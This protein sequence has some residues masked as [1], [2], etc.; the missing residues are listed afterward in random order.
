MV[1]QKLTQKKIDELLRLIKKVDD[2]TFEVHYN[3]ENYMTTNG[4]IILR[5]KLM[6]FWKLYYDVGIHIDVKPLDAISNSIDDVNF[7][8]SE[9][10]LYALE[11]EIIKF[12]FPSDSYMKEKGWEVI[13]IFLD[14][15]CLEYDDSDNM[16]KN[17]DEE[18]IAKAL[19]KRNFGEYADHLKSLL[20]FQDAVGN[21]W[22]DPCYS[23]IMK[24][25]R[26][27]KFME[28]AESVPNI[29][30]TKLYKQVKTLIDGIISPFEWHYTDFESN[31]VVDGCLYAFTTGGCILE[32]GETITAIHGKLYRYLLIEMLDV[33][34]TKAEKKFGYLK[35]DS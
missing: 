3:W 7:E 31:I 2:Y 9:D 21:E 29:K 27:G 35:T 11:D 4:I 20:A 15:N 19:C 14:Y 24:S 23:Q 26:A 17:L 30:R 28:Y 18:G 13:E 1:S 32:S 12:V 25:E 34:L 16:Y 33:L 8:L 6:A 10:Y 22:L 5:A